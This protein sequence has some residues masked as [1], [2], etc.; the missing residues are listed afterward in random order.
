LEAAVKVKAANALEV[1]AKQ[2]QSKM[3]GKQLDPDYAI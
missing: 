2:A 1:A 3:Q